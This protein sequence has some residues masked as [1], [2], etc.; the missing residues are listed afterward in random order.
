MYTTDSYFLEKIRQ[1][2]QKDLKSQGKLGATLKQ[3]RKESKL[4][5]SELSEKYRISISYIS[6]IENDQMKPNVSYIE[7]MLNGLDINEDMFESSMEMDEWYKLAINHH[8]DKE[9][10]SI[11]LKDYLKQRNDFQ[12]KLIEFSLLVKGNE[13]MNANN[14]I[15]LLMHSIDQMTSMEFALYIFSLVEHH[16]NDSDII[17]ASKVFAEMNKTYLLCEGLE[18]WAYKIA[19]KLSEFH[20]SL[21]QFEAIY[22]TYNKRLLKHNMMDILQRNREIY[23]GQQ[24]FHSPISLVN[25]IDDEM[26]KNYRISLVLHGEVT[27][28]TNLEKT[29]DLAQVLYEDIYLKQKPNYHH[30]S[31]E[32]SL[33][34]QTLLEYFKMKYEKNRQLYFLRE[35]VFSMSEATQHHYIVRF[36]ADRLVD[37]LSSQN[38]YKEC[39]LVEKRIRQLRNIKNLTMIFNKNL[40]FFPQI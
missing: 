31:F 33:F 37:L 17:S 22:H 3:R 32:P 5:L 23:I 28:F 35:M 14:H 40:S 21:E 30:I 10:N 25:A 4:T 7:P 6:K 20:A 38:K 1:R 27:T 26:Y 39:H 12:S 15:S 19:F 18:I 8:I 9:N 13:Y 16:I 36:F 11:K 29:Y 34:E 2:V 24:P